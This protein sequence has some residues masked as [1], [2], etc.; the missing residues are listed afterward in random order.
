M[1]NILNSKVFI[2]EDDAF[3]CMLY[4]KQLANLGFSDM[5][6]FFNGKDCLD[7][8]DMNPEIALLDHQMSD[9]TGLELL[10]KIKRH[11]PDCFV[12]MVSAQEDMATALN[13]LKQG[14]FDYIIKGK[15]DANQIERTLARLSQLKEVIAPKQQSLIKRLFAHV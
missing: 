6:H 15:D 5:L 9:V 7:N 12:I 2:V 4:K 1:N 14:A 10:G 11:N 13:A 3:T 8:I